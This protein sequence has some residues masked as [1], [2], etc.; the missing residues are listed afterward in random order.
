MLFKSKT[1]SHERDRHR[2]METEMKNESR[3]PTPT[4]GASNVSQRN[5]WPQVPTNG[6]SYYY[7][8]GASRRPTRTKGRKLIAFLQTWHFWGSIQEWIAT[9]YWNKKQPSQCRF[10][11]LYFFGHGIIKRLQCLRPLLSV[12]GRAPVTNDG[13][14]SVTER[15][16]Q[17]R[18]HTHTHKHTHTLHSLAE[19]DCEMP[20]VQHIHTHSHSP[21]R[22]IINDDGERNVGAK[23]GWAQS[24]VE[25]FLIGS[26]SHLDQPFPKD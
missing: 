20:S 14:Q 5:N 10:L 17:H 21:Y 11:S 9:K 18:P 2:D 8:R 3:P 19:M 15:Q 16:E 23:Q 1:V 22:L 13:R 24:D 7:L 26:K 12:S 25:R 4:L 6:R